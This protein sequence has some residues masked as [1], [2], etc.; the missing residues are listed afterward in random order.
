[1]SAV[2]AAQLDAILACI[3][4]RYAEPGLSPAKIA[5]SQDISLRYFH[6]LIETT[7]ISFTKRVNEL[8][9]NDAFKR[10]TDPRAA[11]LRISDIALQCGFSDISHFNRLFVARFG[12]VPSAIRH[13]AREAVA[14]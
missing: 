7:G 6:R 12:D 9:L 13:S 10:L 3:E 11:H 4:L 5:R 8:R 14:P 1:M 2:V